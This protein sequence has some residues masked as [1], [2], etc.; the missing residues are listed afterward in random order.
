MSAP[1]AA[2]FLTP[3]GLV[4]DTADRRRFI[5]YLEEDDRA[6]KARVER[7]GVRLEE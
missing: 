2:E 1:E 5:A 6:W 7:L 4:A 3:N